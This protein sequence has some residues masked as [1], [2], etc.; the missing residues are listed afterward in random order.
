MSPYAVSTRH[1][2]VHTITHK[3]QISSNTTLIFVQLLGPV[4]LH[5]SL[6]VWLTIKTENGTTRI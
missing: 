6:R 5:V 4:I 2:Q 1:N 3:D